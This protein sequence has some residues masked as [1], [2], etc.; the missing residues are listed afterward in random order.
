VKR[1][2]QRVAVQILADGRGPPLIQAEPEA[3]AGCPIL[4]YLVVVAGFAASFA[5]LGALI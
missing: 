2:A 1:P 4:T 5:L 3:S